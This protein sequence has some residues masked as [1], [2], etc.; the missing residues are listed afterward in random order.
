[1]HDVVAGLMGGLGAQHARGERTQLRGQVVLLQPSN[2]PAATLR[3][4]TPGA[5][6]TTGASVDDVAL[7]KISTSTPRFAIS[8]AVCRT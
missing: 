1:M 7:V 6:G 4:S 3:T 8:R 2:G 5:T